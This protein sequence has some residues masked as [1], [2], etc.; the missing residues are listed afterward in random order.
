MEASSNQPKNEEVRSPASVG[1]EE[2]NWV[3]HWWRPTGSRAVVLGLFTITLIAGIGGLVYAAGG[4][5]FAW[6]HLMYLPIILAAAAFGIRGGVATAILAGLALGPLI[7]MDVAKGL[8]QETFSWVFRM[9]FFVLI[10]GF[11]GLISKILN[12]QINRLKETHRNLLQAHE[13]LKSA[14]MK[15]IQTAKLESI[16]RLAAGVAHEVKNPLAVIQLGVDYLASTAKG[17]ANRDYIET[18]QDMGDAVKRADFVIKGLLN[19]SRS[20]QLNLVPLDLNQV[21]EESLAMVKHEF[22]KNHISLEKHL[23]EKLPQVELDRSKIEQVLINVF[24]NAIQAMGN[25]G[26][27]SV[28]TFISRP[29]GTK[30]AGKR[31]VVEIQDTGSGIPEDKLDKLFEPFF[32]TKPVGTGTGLGLSV[33]RNIIELHRATIRIANRKETHGVCV[34]ISFPIPNKG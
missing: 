30:A 21:I 3:D 12:G 5:T 23:A 6:V 2:K 13:E 29:T 26:E 10:G 1:V 22:A 16:G 20:E 18:V 27:L 19:F 15:L 8:P 28:K 9:S 24:M 4:T 14:Q 25:N 11:S 34:T 17:T 31:V 33:S 7:P 32:T